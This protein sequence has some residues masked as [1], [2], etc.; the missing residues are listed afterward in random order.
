[1]NSLSPSTLISSTSSSALGPF[2]HLLRLSLALL[3]GTAAAAYLPLR[4]RLSDKQINAV[5]TF[6]TGRA[7]LPLPFTPLYS[8]HCPLS[9]AQ[10]F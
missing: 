4:V 3:V 7:P 5:S 1:M 6:S 10:A 8:L 2:L 9:T